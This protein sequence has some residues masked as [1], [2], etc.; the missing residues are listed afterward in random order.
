MLASLGMV[1]EQLTLRHYVLLV[2]RLPV[3]I[4]VGFCVC[5]RGEFTAYLQ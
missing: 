5:C 4:L 3:T 1:I 2:S